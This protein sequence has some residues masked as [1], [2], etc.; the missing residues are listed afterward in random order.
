MEDFRN[1]CLF[2]L[3]GSLCSVVWCYSGSWLHGSGYTW[4]REPCGSL[5]PDFYGFVNYLIFLIFWFFL[6]KQ[7]GFY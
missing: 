1:F 3:V 2:L 6:V 5:W 7:D 4:F